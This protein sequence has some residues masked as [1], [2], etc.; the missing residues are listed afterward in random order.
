MKT[1]EKENIKSTVYK[2]ALKNF[3][4]NYLH[5]LKLPT[6]ENYIEV[7]LAKKA[8]LDCYNNCLKKNM[9]DVISGIVKNRY[10]CFSFEQI[11]KFEEVL[12]LRAERKSASIKIIT[13][14]QNYEHQ[15]KKMGKKLKCEYSNLL[16]EFLDKLDHV[17]LNTKVDQK[18]P[19]ATYVS[20]PTPSKIKLSEIRRLK[21][22]EPE[23]NM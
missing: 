19:K 2:Q 13:H 18:F 17:E 4:R 12:M 1:Q 14:L 5:F 3:E 7:K 20:L 23:L 9:Q 6:L 15:A 22:Y 21:D 16:I 11:P 10:K 8:Y